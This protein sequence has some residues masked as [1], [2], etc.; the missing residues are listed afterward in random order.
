[1]ADTYED[2][3][4]ADLPGKE[5]VCGEKEKENRKLRYDNARKALDVK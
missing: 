3:T 2:T 5:D 1:M 4:V